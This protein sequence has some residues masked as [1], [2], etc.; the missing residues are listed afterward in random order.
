MTTMTT[1]TPM[2]GWDLFEDLRAAQDEMMREARGRG[3]R[4]GQPND[5]SGAAAWASGTSRT[6]PPRRRC[7]VARGS[8]APSAAR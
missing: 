4:P 1:M 7:T 3:W 5:A 6:T 2:T 8:T